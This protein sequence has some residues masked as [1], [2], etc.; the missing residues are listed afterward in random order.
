MISARTGLIAHLETGKAT[1]S[2]ATVKAYAGEIR[3]AITNP[4][5]LTDILPAVLVLLD[6]GAR[7][8]G[9]G[10]YVF[11][12]LIISHTNDLEIESNADDALQIAEDLADWLEGDFSWS[13]SSRAY[14]VDLGKGVRIDTL[15]IEPAYTVVQVTI[16]VM[17]L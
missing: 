3:E 16:D 9:H 8:E 10:D 7:A 5:V 13:H 15:M 17:E 6:E 4:S 11:Q 14:S 2:A 1:F 12:L